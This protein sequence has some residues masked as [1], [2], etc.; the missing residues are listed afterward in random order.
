MNLKKKIA[1]AVT[2]LS[3]KVAKKA[4][5]QVSTAGTYQPKEP[6]ISNRK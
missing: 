1:K 6:T 3:L 4:M 5:G 2:E